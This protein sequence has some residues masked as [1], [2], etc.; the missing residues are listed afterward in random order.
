[1]DRRRTWDLARQAANVA[2]A[3]FQVGMTAYAST[4]ISDVVDEGPRS[5][6]EPA[7]YAFFI[8]GVI[9]SLSLAY[10]VYQARPSRREDPLLRRIGWFTAAAFACTG[11][12]SVFVPREQTL[13]AFGVFLVA[14][15]CLLV[16]YLRVAGSERRAGRG[17]RWLVALPIGIFLG[18]VTAADLVSAHAALVEGGYL[19]PGGTAEAAVGAGLLLLGGVL[20]AGVVA[21]GRPGPVQGYAAYGGTVLWALAG[22]VVNQYGVEPLTA[23]AALIAAVPVALALGGWPPTFAQPGR[24]A[25]RTAPSGAG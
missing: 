4:R 13:S 23:G 14:W 11:V 24:G 15:V 3:L 8:W 18:W 19:A 20:A 5:P 7:L 22:V 21:A 1:M 16:A 17:T 10:A 6:V 12:W 9:F 25:S 2:G